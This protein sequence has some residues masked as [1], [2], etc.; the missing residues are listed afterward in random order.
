[1]MLSTREFQSCNKDS[2]LNHLRCWEIKNTEA[3]KKY[4]KSR[5]CGRSGNGRMEDSGSSTGRQ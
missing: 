2:G 4:R 3:R 5:W 1:M